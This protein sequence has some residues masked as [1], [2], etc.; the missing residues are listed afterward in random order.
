MRSTVAVRSKVVSLRS[1]ISFPFFD[2]GREIEGR[3]LGSLPPG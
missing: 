2:V 1:C 3:L